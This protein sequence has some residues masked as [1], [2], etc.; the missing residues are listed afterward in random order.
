MRYTTLVVAAGLLAAPAFAS[1]EEPQPTVWST[2]AV[3]RPRAEVDHRF[4]DTTNFSVSH[5]A[6]AGVGA[7]KESFSAYLEAQDVRTWGTEPSTLAHKAQ[8]DLHQ[9]YVRYDG[10]KPF[11]LTAGRQEINLLNQRL[12]GAVDWNQ[13]GRAF[14]AARV[15]GA[16]NHVSWDGFAGVTS[17]A[18]GRGNRDYGAAGAVFAWDNAGRKLAAIGVADWEPGKN[19]HTRYTVGPYSEGKLLQPLTY[20]LEAYSQTGSRAKA[21]LKAYFFSAEV[22]YASPMLKAV[23]GYDRASGKDTRKGKTDGYTAFDTLYATNHKFYGMMD[24]FTA[25]P[26]DTGGQGLQDAYVGVTGIRGAASLSLTGHRFYTERP[27]GEYFGTEGDI[28]AAYG[29]TKNVS[30]QIGYGALVAGTA[31]EK[32]N[33]KAPHVPN[34]GY[35]MVTAAF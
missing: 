22:G 16:Y 4:G 10:G 35:S 33:K 9:G 24:L 1:A 8:V 6:R 23:A 21:D 18:T 13:V 17:E 3:Y 15:A 27:A 2:S 20:R 34:W 14:D 7:A 32:V 19:Q 25:L 31:F 26:R 28:L 5:R 12:V 11:K 29:F 30:A